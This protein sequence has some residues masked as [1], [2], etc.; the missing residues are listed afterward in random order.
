MSEKKFFDEINSIA[1]FPFVVQKSTLNCDYEMHSHDFSELVIILG[2][3]AT[4]IIASEEYAIKAGDIYVINSNI[5]HGFKEVFNLELCNMIYFPERF[6]GL[7]DKL[8][9]MPGYHA[10]FVLEPFY[11]EEDQFNCRLQ[12][13]MDKLRYIETII[14]QI[15]FEYEKKADGFKLLIESYFTSLV[16][17]LSREYMLFQNKYTKETE[18]LVSLAEAV[19]FIEKNFRNPME[20][21]QFYSRVYFS[22]RHFIRIFKQNYKYSPQDYIIQLR[23]RFACKLLGNSEM[24]ITQIAMSSGFSDSNYF[25]RQ[26]KKVYGL[27]PREY[28]NLLMMKKENRC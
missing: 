15:V 6:S 19:S 4:H 20:F 18:R 13:P 8:K 27:A 24:N 28:K 11:R 1:N 16:V 25:S 12:L 17:Y 7:Q 23:L 14:D 2:G 5:K 26:F 21:E 22:K 9:E 10:L 3:H